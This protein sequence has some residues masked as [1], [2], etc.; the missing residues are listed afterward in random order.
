MHHLSYTY[1]VSTPSSTHVL[2]E[3]DR[4]SHYQSEVHLICTISSQNTTSAA[5][6]Q[7]VHLLSCPHPLRI[8][9]ILLMSKSSE[10]TISHAHGLSEYYLS[11]PCPVV[12]IYLAHVQSMYYLSSLHPIS[13]LL[14]MAMSSQNTT[15]P[16]HVQSLHHLFCPCPVSLSILPN[17]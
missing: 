17:T 9:P 15:S 6:V 5:L 4:S 13:T 1:P 7:P 2:S 3:Y 14:Y 10:F 12:H 11:Y 16:V 8:P